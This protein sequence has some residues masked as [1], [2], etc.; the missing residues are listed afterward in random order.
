MYDGIER[1]CRHRVDEQVLQAVA[2]LDTAAVV[3]DRE[4][5]VEI[6]IVAEHRLHK[7]VMERIVLEQRVVGLEE[8]ISTVLILRRLSLIADELAA[9]KDE[10]AHLSLTITLHLKVGAEGVDSLHTDTV[11]TDTLFKCLGI[12]LTTGIQ[13][14]HGFHKLTLWDATAIVAHG[15]AEVVLNIHLNAVTGIH[16]KLIDGVVDDLLQQ[17]IDTVFRQVAIPQSSDIH[18]RTCPHMLHIRQVSD[19]VVSVLYCIVV[20]LLIH[21]SPFYNIFFACD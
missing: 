7:L 14:R 9:L 1:V 2:A 12:I 13:H 6:G 17:D 3:H 8:D 16:L 19:I 21:L 15:D 18:A 4:T 20:I 5:T 10:C 11:Q